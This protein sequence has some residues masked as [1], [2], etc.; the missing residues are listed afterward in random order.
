MPKKDGGKQKGGLPPSWGR[1][2][3]A[4]NGRKNHKMTD[5]PKKKEDEKANVKAIDY[6]AAVLKL[7]FLQ[8][9]NVDSQGWQWI[10]TLCTQTENYIR[11]FDQYRLNMCAYV[12]VLLVGL[13][14][15]AGDIC[16]RCYPIC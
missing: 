10:E 15:N 13:R 1:V 12:W 8:L 16:L 9:R 5:D 7:S 3:E 2:R 6:N 11:N 14:R 4:A